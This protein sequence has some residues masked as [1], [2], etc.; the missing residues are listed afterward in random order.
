[1]PAPITPP[2][3]LRMAV[4]GGGIGGLCLA[5]ALSK[6]SDIQVDVY[7]AAEQL[8]EIGAGVIFWERTWE[9]F[10]SMG[11]SDDLTEVSGA[12]IDPK[13][14]VGFDYFRS[15]SPNAGHQFAQF[16]PPC[17]LLG[18]TK[19][20][21]H[22][23]IILQD[24]CI[25]FHRA[26]FLD[27]LIKHLPEGIAHLK[28]RLLSYEDTDHGITLNFA[29]GTTASADLLVGCDGIKSVVRKQMY[30]AEAAKGDPKLLQFIDP[31]WSG[32]MIYRA[33]APAERLFEACNGRR[34]RIMDDAAVYCG[35]NKHIV[36]YAVGKGATTVNIVAFAT[37]PE[38]EGK[39][40]DGPWVTGCSADEV[41]NHFVDQPLVWALHCLKPLPFY[42]KGQVTLLGDAAHA[43]LP[44]Q[45]VG[46]VQAIEDAYLLAGLLGDAA[47]TKDTL[48]HALH[49][50]EATRLPF[51][52]ARMAGSRMNGLMY[53]FNSEHG[54]NY[55]TLAPAIT[56]QWN[57][58]WEN[59]A[60]DE[61]QKALLLMRGR[62][63][64]M[65]VASRG[66]NQ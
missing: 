16:K 5:L 7:E 18:L 40:Y 41:R 66:S 3:K 33:L 50:Y 46:A 39:T 10:R 26:H 31:V 63:K 25:R 44:H 43:M 23:E 47:V 1:M 20:L 28:K 62:I 38:D 29:D 27:V 34:H 49:A 35:K 32:T 48:Q 4:V 30:E 56:S 51:A 19:R 11:L 54:D 52:N 45:G 24:G 64:T 17:K 57:W 55:E 59:T 12:P 15:D 60:E 22:A 14:S 65:P 36:S 8:K 2:P 37:N 13:P 9:V 6:H 21:L 58:Q 53:E 61:V 42:T